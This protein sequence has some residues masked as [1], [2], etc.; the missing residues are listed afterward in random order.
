M[1]KVL[2][3]LLTHP[4]PQPFNRIEVWA[5]A[6]QLDELNAEL[7]GLG[8]NALA[9]MPRR[10]IPDDDQLPVGQSKPSD[11]SAQKLNRMFTVA[12]ALL[13]MKARPALKS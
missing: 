1:T 11:E 7:L 4:F 2:S 12:L 3:D 6:R 13:P 10:T 5:I 9:A 8:V